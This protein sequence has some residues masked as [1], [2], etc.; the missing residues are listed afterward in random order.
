MPGGFAA[1]ISASIRLVNRQ[2]R[3]FDAPT[4]GNHANFQ[5]PNSWF[6]LT[7]QV[8]KD[9]PEFRRLSFNKLRKRNSSGFP[10]ADW[11]IFLGQRR[12]RS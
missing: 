10:G 1:N 2:G 7:E 8:R 6:R 4:K 9:D 3:R 11:H 5:I 12:A